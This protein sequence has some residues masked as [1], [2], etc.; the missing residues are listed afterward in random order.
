MKNYLNDNSYKIT[1][2]FWVL[3]VDDVEE[4]FKV[5]DSISVFISI[6]NHLINFNSWKVL[7]NAGCNL[8]K[9]LRTEGSLF[10]DIKVFEELSNRGF[11]ISI[12]AE[13]EDFEE[14]AKV[15]FLRCGWSWDNTN[16]LL[17]LVFNTKG[18]D[19]VDQFFTRDISTFIVIEDVET[20]FKLKNGIF[21]E[22]FANVFLGVELRLIKR[23]PLTFDLFGSWNYNKL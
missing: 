7:S 4:F 3:F 5:N 11:A 19:G 15:H 21:W 16:D 12:T 18:S 6:V 2:D 14:G 10:I 1:S 17:S 23:L 13:S 20:F 22:V 9:F 8:F